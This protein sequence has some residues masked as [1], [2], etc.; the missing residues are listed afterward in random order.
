TRVALADLGE[1][2]GEIWLHLL[3][4]AL[5][6]PGEDAS[7]FVASVGAVQPLELRRHLL[8]VHVPAWNELIGGDV[9]E[10]AVRGDGRAAKRLPRHDPYSRGT[11]PAVRAAGA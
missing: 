3:G 5:E 2:A 7:T 1:R 9:L 11:V 4:L 8:G 6:Q 10:R